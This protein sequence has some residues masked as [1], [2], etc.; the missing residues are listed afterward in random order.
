MSRLNAYRKDLYQRWGRPLVVRLGPWWFRRHE[1]WRH[2]VSYA[3]LSGGL[4]CGLGGA[5][6][7]LLM[8]GGA[9]PASWLLWGLPWGLLVLGWGLLSVTDCWT[10]GARLVS[11]K[12]YAS[13]LARAHE[14][15][16]GVDRLPLLSHFDGWVVMQGWTA[17]E[18]AKKR[19]QQL[20]QALPPAQPSGAQNRER[21]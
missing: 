20:A 10:R 4:V 14:L 18:N 1:H 6:G 15:R 9:S 3:L 8:M 19:A 21:F 16:W 2:L 5:M 17:L 11:S 12:R 7:L 13:L